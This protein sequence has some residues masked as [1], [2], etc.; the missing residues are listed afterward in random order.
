MGSGHGCF[1]L[2]DGDR[3]FD[4]VT[5]I[6]KGQTRVVCV[7]DLVIGLELNWVFWIGVGDFL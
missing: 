7:L 5:V 6:W 4:T 2:F 1:F 3:N